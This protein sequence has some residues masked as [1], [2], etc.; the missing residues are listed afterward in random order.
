M[1]RGVRTFR[2][3]GGPASKLVGLIREISKDNSISFRT[4]TVASPPPNLRIEVDGVGRILEKDDV[5]VAEDLIM[6]TRNIM[7]RGEIIEATF[8]GRIDVGDRVLMIA[9]D[10]EYGPE[11]A[12]IDKAVR[13]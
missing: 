12:V 5:I 11:Y 3:E 10:T 7:L 6:H 13:L 4:G 9:Y 2:G 1:G 8:S